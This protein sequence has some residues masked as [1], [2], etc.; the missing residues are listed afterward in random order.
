MLPGTDLLELRAEGNDPFLLEQLVNLWPAA[1]ETRRRQ[2]FDP[3]VREQI[4][5]AE[6]E[7]GLLMRDDDRPVPVVAGLGSF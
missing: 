4:A 5:A 7:L 1:Y 2:A 3:S 6:S